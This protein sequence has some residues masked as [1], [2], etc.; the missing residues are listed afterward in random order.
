MTKMRRTVRQVLELAE[1]GKSIRD[2][3]EENG[4]ANRQFTAC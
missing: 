2:I 3:A 1:A 4:E